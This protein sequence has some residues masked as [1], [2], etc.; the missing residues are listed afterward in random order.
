MYIFGK[1][2]KI[3]IKE[4]RLG[5]TKALLTEWVHCERLYNNILPYFLSQKECYVTNFIF[6]KKILIR[7]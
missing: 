6:I 3:I 7:E 4:S 5:T 1:I 2:L